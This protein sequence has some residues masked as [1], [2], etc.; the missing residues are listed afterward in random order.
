[1]DTSG[2]SLISKKKEKSVGSTQFSKD[3]LQT[4][5][6]FGAQNLFKPQEGGD[7]EVAIPHNKLEDLN[8]DEIL[9]RAEQHES[10]EATGAVD[11]GADFLEQWRVEDVVMNNLSWDDIIPEKDR[12]KEEE[13]VEYLGPRN[14][15]PVR[16]GMDGSKG[17]DE[18]SDEEGGRKRKR[19]SGSGGVGGGEKKKKGATGKDPLTEKE[20]RALVRS[21]LKFGSLEERYQDIVADSELD[22][23]DK[24]AV[25]KA[26]QT[27]VDEAKKAV[28]A[29]QASEEAK[30]DSGNASKK[31]NKQ[32]PIPITVNGAMLNALQLMQRI[33]DLDLLSSV[34]GAVKD[35]LR[36]RLST[37]LKAPS[38]TCQWG[39]LDDA[40]LLVGIHKHGYGAWNQ[41]QADEALPFKNK[42]FLEK[43]ED[44]GEGGNDDEEGKD[45]KEKDK[46]GKKG[47]TKPLPGRIHLGRR[48]DA[49][50]KLL[51]EE[52][53]SR[54]QKIQQ[55]TA[56]QKVLEEKRAKKR[57]ADSAS[58]KNKLGGAEEASGTPKKSAAQQV[59]DDSKK[60]KKEVTKPKNAIKKAESS[61]K[62][63]AGSK[64]PKEPKKTK[65]AA[66]KKSAKPTE[67]DDSS[68]AVSESDSES[69]ITKD[70]DATA[71]KEIM[72][73]VKKDLTALRNNTKTMS[74]EEKPQF[75]RESMLKIGNHINLVLKQTFKE[76]EANSEAKLKLERHL[77]KFASLFWPVDIKMEPFR[78]VYEKVVK[79]LEHSPNAATSTAN[80]TSNSTAKSLA[81]A[82]KQSKEGTSSLKDKERDSGS[83]AKRKR[84]RSRSRSRDRDRDRERDRDRDRERDREREREREKREREKERDRDRDHREKER[85][86][87][88]GDRDRERDREREKDRDRDH[89]DR[90]RSR[91]RDRRRS[92]SRSRSRERDSK[93]YR[94]S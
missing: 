76:A 86:R 14:V 20:N 74:K 68:S 45:S 37:S 78:S 66:P 85:E 77:W 18:S 55:A 38:W 81:S 34:I 23:R 40:M 64:E 27:I 69:E 36:Y 39:S 65:T 12:S 15:K 41:M 29:S 10:E 79:A 62:K 13:V 30:D 80:S 35:P 93:R 11:G 83:D 71:C 82:V 5:L 28:D 51:R 6:K 16:Y 87:D 63:S 25:V 91:S 33:T 61:A 70:M 21:I 58:A 56:K 44:D 90:R 47:A 32:K 53:E 59:K 73:P 72:R 19:K 7:G 60:V 17:D 24:D 3:E 43:A 94:T 54:K 26:Y 2:E 31:S 8:L 49:L 46:D 52:N 75:I 84:E 57:E 22:E 50:L 1:M 92:R 88:R 9:S 89:R 42:F 48:A 4:I 67:N